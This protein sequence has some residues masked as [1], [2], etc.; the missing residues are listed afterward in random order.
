[1]TV[2]YDVPETTTTTTTKAPEEE[3][4]FTAYNVYGTC[5]ESP[6]YDVYWG[7]APPGAPIYVESEYGSGSTTANENGDW[8]LKVYFPEAPAEKEFTVKVKD[9]KGNKFYFGFKYLV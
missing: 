7:T 9:N 6:P 3:I 2:H 1:M 8:E 4:E 5:D